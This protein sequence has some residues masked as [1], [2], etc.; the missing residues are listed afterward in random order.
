MKLQS[1][2]WRCLLALILL[3]HAAVPVVEA[4]TDGLAGI[5]LVRDRPGQAD[6]FAKAVPFQRMGAYAVVTN[7]YSGASNPLIVENVRIAH[8]VIF[9]DV[10]TRDLIDD[11]DKG[12]LQHKQDELKRVSQKFPAARYAVNPLYQSLTISLQKMAEGQVRFRGAWISSRSYEGLLAKQREDAEKETARVK[13]AAD[14]RKQRDANLTSSR[15]NLAARW[16]LK[17]HKNYVT[18][19]EKQPAGGSASLVVSE[20][21]STGALLLPKTRA[22]EVAL[23]EGASPSS[24]AFLFVRQQNRCTSFRLAF[25]IVYEDREIANPAELQAAVNMLSQLD[26]GMASWLPMAVVSGQTKLVLLKNSSRKM[27]QVTVSREVAAMTCLVTVTPET[28]NEDGS[29]FS[30]VCLTVR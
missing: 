6:E 1:N 22:G 9:D 13:A 12:F 27:E 17:D 11:A 2:C 26:S 8:V 29:V 18:D 10:E 23:K 19:L 24:P 28:A 16:L 30:V 21:L 15:Q 7:F 14:D 5:A 25:T 20:A 4:Q 3:C